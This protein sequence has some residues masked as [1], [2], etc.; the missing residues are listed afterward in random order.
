MSVPNVNVLISNQLVR[1][2]DKFVF[3]HGPGGSMWIANHELASNV[4]TRCVIQCCFWKLR[5]RQV[6]RYRFDVV[7]TVM[8]STVADYVHS[9]LSMNY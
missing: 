9:L 6:I 5:S 2:F 1:L 7:F 4:M 8:W 3:V